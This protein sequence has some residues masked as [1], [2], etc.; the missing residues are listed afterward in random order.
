MLEM[1]T[2]L[3]AA[4]TLF[5]NGNQGEEE[6]DMPHYMLA[7]QAIHQLGDIGRDKPD[8]CIIHGEDEE[9]YIGRWVAGFGF[10]NVKFPKS[11]TRELTREEKKKWDGKKIVINGNIIGTISTKDA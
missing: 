7:T 10:I 9:N 3:D 1:Y 8:L 11:T 5:P 4:N 6:A 2:S